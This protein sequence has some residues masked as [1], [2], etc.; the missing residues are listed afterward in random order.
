MNEIFDTKP[1]SVK[2]ARKKKEL[3]EERKQQLREQL[4]RYRKKKADAKALADKSTV[5]EQ[6]TPV[7]QPVQEKTASPIP[8]K[9]VKKEVKLNVGETPIEEILETTLPESQCEEPPPEKKNI[10]V[11]RPNSTSRMEELLEKLVKSQEENDRKKQ[12]KEEA[13]KLLLEE[14]LL[15]LAE[16]PKTIVV[17]ESKPEPKPEPKPEAP[18]PEA[19]KYRSMPLNIPKRKRDEVY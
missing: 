10:S 17:P 7:K 6:T 2:P 14:K 18:K 3:S 4:A 9:V 16:Q 19:P 11:P 15:K 1:Q 13:R 8:K 5:E 12:I